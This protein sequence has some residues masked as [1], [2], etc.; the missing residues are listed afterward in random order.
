MNFQSRKISLL[1]G[2]S[3]LAIAACFSNAAMAGTYC[4]PRVVIDL[5]GL[6]PFTVDTAEGGD[7]IICNQSI[8]NDDLAF[9]SVTGAEIVD[10]S[11]GNSDLADGAVDNAKIGGDAVTSDKIQDGAVGNDDLAD[12]SVNSQKIENGSVNVVSNSTN[13]GMVPIRPRYFSV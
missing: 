11:V 7:E 5:I 4:G 10:G 3:A 2:F 9:D 12:N 8:N 6:D 13:P 1:T